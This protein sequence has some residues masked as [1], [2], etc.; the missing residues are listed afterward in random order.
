MGK[1]TR[2]RNR[3]EHRL[4]QEKKT[5]DR[6]RRLKGLRAATQ[7]DLMRAIAQAPP[8]PRTGHR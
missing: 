8:L 6:E 2:N 5:V 1:M 3:R 7:G 4:A